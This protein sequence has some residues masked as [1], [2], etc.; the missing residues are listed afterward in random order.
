M[1]CSQIIENSWHEAICT[2]LV[3]ALNKCD[4]DRL[5]EFAKCFLKNVSED[6]T[7][8]DKVWWSDEAIFKINGHI[9]RH[10]CVYW[11][12]KNPNIVIEKELDL[13]GVTVW[14]AIFSS[15]IIGP[16]FFDITVISQ[17]YLEMLKEKFW[18]CIQHQEIIFQQDGT[19]AHYGRVVQ[20]WLN[21][22]FGKR[23]IGHRS[24]IEWPPRSLD[25]SP[26]DFFLWGILKDRVYRRKLR[27]IE[28]LKNAITM[29][30]LAINSNLC[31]MVC[32]SVTDRLQQCLA[33]EGQQ[34]EYLS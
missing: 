8:V 7:Y 26:C 18:P 28:K 13:P 4:P 16:F 25:L 2:L 3:Q 21:E 14:C 10:N 24:F 1:E 30:I 5:M 34:F 33:V 15:G 11:S 17:S 9:N 29:E 32:H 27:S 20:E 22:K 12:T 19:P 23:W 6:S 31:Q